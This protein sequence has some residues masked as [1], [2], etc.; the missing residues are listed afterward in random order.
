LELRLLVVAAQ[1]LLQPVSEI[2]VPACAVSMEIRDMST[3][4]DAR[5]RL[6]AERL[7][8]LGPRPLF[9]FLKELFAGAD[10]TSRLEAYARLAPLAPFIAELDGDQARK[11]HL[12]NGG[13]R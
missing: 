3:I 11:L 2:K 7:H 13:R 1:Q 8:C 12:V 6:L 4:T 10:I 5:L 9:E